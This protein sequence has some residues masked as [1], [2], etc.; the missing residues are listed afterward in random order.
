MPRTNVFRGCPTR[1][2]A[3]SS[4]DLPGMST[5]CTYELYILT[6][7]QIAMAAQLL[8]V[9][10]TLFTKISVLITYLRMFPIARLT[11]IADFSDIFPSKTNKYFC[12]GNMALTVV[13]AFVTFFVA[14]FQCR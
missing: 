6:H 9:P 7:Y 5:F 10:L 13:W 14:L 4:Q 2:S 8:Y 1:Y 12:W 3:Q 11:K